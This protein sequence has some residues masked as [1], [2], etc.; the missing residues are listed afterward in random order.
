MRKTRHIGL[1]G[2]QEEGHYYNIRVL[3]N[4]IGKILDRGSWMGTNNRG[5]AETFLIRKKVDGGGLCLFCGCIDWMCLEN[6]HPDK[7]KMPNFSVTLCANCH[8]KVHWMNGDLS[9]W[10]SR[11]REDK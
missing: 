7:I 3:I 6:H 4:S 8:R 5:K 2:W 9:K 10:N 1:Y 11:L